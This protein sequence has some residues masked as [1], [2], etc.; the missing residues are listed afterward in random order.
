[1]NAVGLAVSSLLLMVAN[2]E[3]AV[4]AGPSV[5]LVVDATGQPPIGSKGMVLTPAPGGAVH[6]PGFP[7]QLELRV[8]SKRTELN[9]RQVV[10]F[11]LTNI[12]AKPIQLPVSVDRFV[13][14][15]PLEMTLYL[16]SPDGRIRGF[17][18]PSALLIGRVGDPKALCLLAPGRSIIVHTLTR[19]DPP[20]GRLSLTA[21]A[22]LSRISKGTSIRIG[23]VNS[24][25][26]E[27]VF[28]NP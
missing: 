28:P 7:L 13:S 19:F 27:H 9:N 23:T 10:D 22:E 1:M 26:V 25:L 11:V 4:G 18:P 17:Y 15:S 16:T 14:N 2:S 12:G 3:I 8:V 6:S 20:A 21:H 24:K 5:Q